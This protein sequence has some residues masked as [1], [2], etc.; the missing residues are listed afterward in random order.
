MQYGGKNILLI[1]LGGTNLRAAF[2][3]RDGIDLDAIQ[4]IKLDR[5]DHFYEILEQLIASKD[6]L[7][8]MLLFLLQDQR[9]EIPLQ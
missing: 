2:G 5:L 8:K 9:M 1:D 6:G 3:S 4:K 7:L